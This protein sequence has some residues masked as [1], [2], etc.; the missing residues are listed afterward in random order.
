MKLK[1]GS[2]PEFFA[3]YDNNGELNVLPPVVLRTDYGA[4]FKENDRHPIF[5][6]YGDT[7]VHEDGAAFEMSTPPS[8][9]WENMWNTIHDVR[10]KFE[11]KFLSK[12][13]V[14]KPTLFS[15]P[16]MKFQVDRWLDRGPAFE[17]ATMFGC[18]ADY[19]VY[20]LKARCKVLDA[21]T[22]PWRYAG[23]HIH[24]SGISEIEEFPLLAVRSMVMTAGLA[25]TAF[26]DVPDLERKRLFLYG[27]PGKFRPQK[28]PNGDTGIEYRTLSTRWTESKSLAEKIF[29]WAEIGMR[30][31]LQGGLLGELAPAIE[32]DAIDSILKVNQDKAKE[33]LSF[34][35]SKI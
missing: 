13:P 34:I 2:D 29:S 31:L 33:L 25:G 4:P 22:H 7:I 17:M 23:G 3:A 18:D 28:Y 6:E 14:C 16:S 19:D 15:L 26:S 1:F 9:S 24:V 21:S 27:K 30:C 10:K 11:K 8:E 35:E 32:N 12:Y 5:A 20:N